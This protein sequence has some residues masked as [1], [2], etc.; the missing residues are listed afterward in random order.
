MISVVTASTVMSYALYT[1]SPDTIRKFGTGNLI[2]TTPFVLYGIFRYLYLVHQKEQGG[3]PT[4]IVFSD[5]PFM[6]NIILW[7]LIGCRIDLQVSSNG[8]VERCFWPIVAAL[9]AIFVF[10]VLYLISFHSQ[11]YDEPTHTVAG[12]LYWK[13][14]EFSGGTANPPLLQLCFGLPYALGLADYDLIGDCPPY[15]GRLVNLV[16]GLVLCL[17]SLALAVRLGGKFSGLVTLGLLVSSPTLLAHSS[18]TTTD[19]GAAAFIVSWMVFHEF[20]RGELSYRTTVL[21]GLLLG[22]TMATKF[23]ALSFLPAAIILVV[24]DILSS[25]HSGKTKWLHFLVFVLCLWVGFCTPYLGKGCLTEKNF[26]VHEYINPVARFLPF[27]AAEGLTRKFGQSTGGDSMFYLL[28]RYTET[29]F[30]YYYPLIILIKTRL[31]TLLIM[32]LVGILAYRERCNLSKEQLAYVLFPALLIFFAFFTNK[33]QGGVRHLLP[34]ISFVF[35]AVGVLCENLSQARRAMTWIAA[36][37]LI[38]IGSSIGYVS[39]SMSFFN[40]IPSLLSSEQFFTNGPD[41]DNAHEEFL[42]RRELRKIKGSLPIHI[43]PYPPYRPVTGY[44]AIN[45]ESYLSPPVSTGYI[46]WLKQFE[47]HSRIGSSWLLYRITENSLR[48]L[49]SR[50]D[51][52]QINIW[53]RYLM[54]QKRY[55]EALRIADSHSKGFS[56]ALFFSAKINLLLKKYSECRKDLKELEARDPAFE[57]ECKLLC[58]VL[59]GLKEPGTSFVSE[60]KLAQALII[61]STKYDFAPNGFCEAI[62]QRALAGKEP[63]HPL[64]G[65][66]ISIFQMMNGDVD[67]GF[68]CMHKLFMKGRLPNSLK[69]YYLAGFVARNLRKVHEKPLPLEDMLSAMLARGQ[70]RFICGPIEGI[71]RETPK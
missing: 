33:A 47:V 69:E 38:N 18:I 24:K 11:A 16:F 5:K 40:L 53:V 71:D 58:I 26:S 29:G 52:N 32:A 12:I 22:L 21:S 1:I 54:G 64:G 7:G 4:S 6:F 28:G 27:W 3:D 45:C 51:W 30:W 14:G 2:F 60:G 42:V 41:T 13:T 59:D 34:A 67:E 68:G 25:I 23:T 62:W 46:S 48:E 20:Y 70:L 43:C 63:S 31:G 17:S 37:L 56:E 8:L 66:C 19:V 10:Q 9:L 49:S 61:L 65:L 57:G 44:V 35:I 39:N 15:A 55:S 36:I 50:T